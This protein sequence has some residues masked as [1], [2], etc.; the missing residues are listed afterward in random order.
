MMSDK[1]SDDFKSTDLADEPHPKARRGENPEP[2]TSAA[3]RRLPLIIGA[4]VVAVALVAG[5]VFWLYGHRAVPTQSSGGGTTVQSSAPPS[6]TP[7]A[8]SSP[9][10]VA[11][12]IDVKTQPGSVDGYVGALK[13]VSGQTCT[14]GPGG[15]T[16]AGTVTNPASSKQ[17]YRIYISILNDNQTLGITEVDINGVDPGASQQWSGVVAVQVDSPKCVLRVERNNSAA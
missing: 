16:A 3:H 13:D 14:A 10:V 7:S 11:P 9:S 15:V 17:D 5:G 1:A 2:K 8:S 6:K 12:V 4:C